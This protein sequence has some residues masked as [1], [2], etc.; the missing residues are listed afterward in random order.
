MT[1]TSASSLNDHVDLLVLAMLLTSVL[2]VANGHRH[3]R[4]DI[5]VDQSQPSQNQLQANYST[6][7]VEHRRVPS[8][9]D[10]EYGLARRGVF[11]R[12]L[13]ELEYGDRCES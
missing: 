4:L 6:V 8:G 1:M 3:S 10:V 5:V 2:P 7:I 11:R 9:G 13:A 12:S